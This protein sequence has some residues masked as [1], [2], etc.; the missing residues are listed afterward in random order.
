MNSC[1][2]A[3]QFGVTSKPEAG[4][5]GY[6]LAL[7]RQLLEDAGGCLLLLSGNE[8][9]RVEGSSVEMGTH[10]VAWQGTVLCLE[11]DT[12]IPLNLGRVYDRWPKVRGYEDDDF[13]FS[14]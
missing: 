3:T 6:G 2:F 7:T 9:L 13:D 5:A 12:R 1:D 10:C 4:H 14:T 8:W 11:W